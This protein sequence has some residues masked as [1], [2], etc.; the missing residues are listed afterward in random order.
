M[1]SSPACSVGWTHT[2]TPQLRQGFRGVPGVTLG[3]V[4]INY[5]G[6]HLLGSFLCVRA[7]GAP[8]SG[9]VPRS[10]FRSSE[11]H[12]RGVLLLGDGS[13]GLHSRVALH[14]VLLL[15]SHGDSNCCRVALKEVRQSRG[16]ARGR[17]PGGLA[18][19][20]SHV[21]LNGCCASHHQASHLSGFFGHRRFPLEVWTI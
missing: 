12:Y 13:G 18:A 3:V 19:G 9:G 6:I 2:H 4:G 1:W 5:G 14:R 20:G 15:G 7:C 21:W 17:A 11:S 10:G 16:R 8:G